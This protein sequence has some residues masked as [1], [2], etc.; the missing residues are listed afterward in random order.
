LDEADLSPWPT[1]IAA[2]GHDSSIAIVEREHG[3]SFPVL[4]PIDDMDTDAF[5]EL[6]AK[7]EHDGGL[8]R[9]QAEL[10]AIHQPRGCL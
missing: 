1:P 8:T 2:N 3:R 5:E 9:E 6:A 7:M 4:N 10:K